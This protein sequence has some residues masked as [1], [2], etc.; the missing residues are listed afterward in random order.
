MG[1]D[2]NLVQGTMQIQVAAHV[3]KYGLILG[4]MVLLGSQETLGAAGSCP[5]R[6][7]RLGAAR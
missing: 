4:T 2:G 7:T 5:L 1:G 3:V 6:R